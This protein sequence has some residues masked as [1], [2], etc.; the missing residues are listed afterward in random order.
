MITIREPGSGVYRNCTIFA[1]FLCICLFISHLKHLKPL[2]FR[3]TVLGKQPSFTFPYPIPNWELEATPSLL[4][5][6]ILLIQPMGA[7]YASDISFGSKAKLWEEGREE[8]T[9]YLRSK[10]FT[11]CPALSCSGKLLILGKASE[12]MGRHSKQ[13]HRSPSASAW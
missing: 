8:N 6:S 9:S 2:I 7:Y 1:T 10:K 5:I 13:G 3:A 4:A 11:H 12:A